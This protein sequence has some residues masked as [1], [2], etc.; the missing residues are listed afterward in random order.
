[1]RLID[2]LSHEEFEPE[3]YHDEYRERVLAAVE[4]KVAGKEVTAGGPE[5]SAPRS[6]T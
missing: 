4:Q 2:E 5:A 1:M 3:Q 6:S